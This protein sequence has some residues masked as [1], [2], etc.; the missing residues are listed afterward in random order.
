M[1]HWSFISQKMYRRRRLPLQHF[2]MHAGE[3]SW[4]CSEV[5]DSSE[6][7]V[8]LLAVRC[9]RN[10]FSRIPQNLVVSNPIHCVVFDSLGQEFGQLAYPTGAVVSCFPARARWGAMTNWTSDL[11]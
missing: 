1:V 7:T 10:L 8:R 11:W 6:I 9:R 3:S 4:R 2:F 5:E